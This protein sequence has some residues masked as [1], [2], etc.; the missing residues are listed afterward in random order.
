MNIYFL[1]EGFTEKKIYPQWLSYLMPGLEQVERFDE[2]ENRNYYIFTA[3]GYP[4]ILEEVKNAAENINDCGK[5]SHLVVCLDADEFTVEERKEE[6][7]KTFRGASFE[8][9]AEL[10][11]IVQ[12]RCFETWFLGNRKVYPRNPQDERLR[13]YTKFYNVSEKDPEIMEKFPGFNR[14]AQFHGDYL[15]RMLGEKNIPYTKKNP[16]GVRESAYVEALQK[17]IKDKPGQ[18]ETLKT[19]FSFCESV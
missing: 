3:G 11:V 19:F 9:K 4:S 7:A 14:I 2:V 5:Y 18:L 13:D 12:N 15:K 1:V 16:R 17:R 6:V 10:V 8:L